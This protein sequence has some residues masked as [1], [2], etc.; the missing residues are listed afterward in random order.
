MNTSVQIKEKLC[1]A[2]REDYLK[3]LLLMYLYP[4]ERI[5]TK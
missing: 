2:E 4:E 1:L 3:R 5:T